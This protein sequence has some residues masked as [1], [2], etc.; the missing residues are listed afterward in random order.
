[1]IL[2]SVSLLIQFVN[3]DGVSGFQTSREGSTRCLKL[4]SLPLTYIRLN[5]QS[6]FENEVIYDYIVFYDVILWLSFL[7]AVDRNS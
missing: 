2:P 6:P 4:H 5:L 3:S 7:S 1:V